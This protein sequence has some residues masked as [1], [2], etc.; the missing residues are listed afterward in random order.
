MVTGWIKEHFRG[1]ST[2]TGASYG[3]GMICTAVHRLNIHVTAFVPRDD[4]VEGIKV[5]VKGTVNR[6]GDAL[7]MHAKDMSCIEII[8]GVENM[9]EDEMD[10]A[11]EAPPLTSVKREASDVPHGNDGKKSKID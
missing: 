3:A 2:S 4:L 11:V 7:I 5:S 10:E 6:R 9:T 1:I 8:P